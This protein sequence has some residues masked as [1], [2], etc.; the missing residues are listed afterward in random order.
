[1]IRI[2]RIITMVLVLILVLTVQ[3]CGGDTGGGKSTGSSERTPADEVTHA[4]AAQ[5]TP[6]T[7]TREPASAP[8]ANLKI[9]AKGIAWNTAALNGLA[10]IPLTI[11]VD[12]QDEGVPHGIAFYDGADATAPII[13][14]ADIA[15]GPVMQTLTIG[16]LDPG[17]YYYMCVV[18]PPMQGVLTV[19]EAGATRHA[20]RDAAVGR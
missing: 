20:R 2:P 16:P 8:S 7:T 10:G 9:I 11:T 17:D 12:N 6:T 5:G 3:A 15:T 18:H 13:V 19:V 1:M 4:P 14:Q